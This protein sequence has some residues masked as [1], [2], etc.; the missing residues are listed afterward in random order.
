MFTKFTLR[1]VYLRSI[2]LLIEMCVCPFIH[3]S[4]S[5]LRLSKRA[6]LGS[7]S[8]ARSRMISFSHTQEYNS[9]SPRFHF[10]SR[11]ATR[12]GIDTKLQQTHCAIFL[13]FRRR[14]RRDFGCFVCIFISSPATCILSQSIML[15]LYFSSSL[16]LFAYGVTVRRLWESL[17]VYLSFSHSHIFSQTVS[18]KEVG[19]RFE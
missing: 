18:G 4:H 6:H 1:W 8:F 17:I 10:H 12:R 9:I 16:Q 3:I 11:F 15:L 14:R 13:H 7:P 2:S 19:G 5:R